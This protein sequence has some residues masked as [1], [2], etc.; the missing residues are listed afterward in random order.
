M[1]EICMSGL[2]RERVRAA[3]AFRPS[4][5][6]CLSALVAELKFRYKVETP[7]TLCHG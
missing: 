6:Y 7:V 4:L 3:Y 1:R 5:L 2:T